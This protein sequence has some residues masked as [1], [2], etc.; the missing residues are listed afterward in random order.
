MCLDHRKIAWTMYIFLGKKKSEDDLNHQRNS[1]YLW[2]YFFVNHC[3]LKLTSLFFLREH[4]MWIVLVI[5]FTHLWFPE[6]EKKDKKDNCPVLEQFLC[7]VAKTGQ[8]VWVFRTGSNQ[9]NDMTCQ[10]K[11]TEL[12]C[13]FLGFRGHNLKHTLCL[14]W[15]RSWMAFVPQLLSREDNITPMSTMF[16]LNRWKIES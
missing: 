11:L 13:P 6:F 4:V 5:I 12:F 9:S 16:P 1:W 15:K 8:P 3:I 10:A 14:S 7:H 2:F